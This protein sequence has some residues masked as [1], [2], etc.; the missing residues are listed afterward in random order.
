[1]P[2]SSP[3]SAF[4]QYKVGRLA[5]ATQ[6]AS[7]AG[8]GDVFVAARAAIVVGASIAEIGG[9]SGRSVEWWH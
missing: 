2:S 5:A 4:N 3:V 9:V 7:S 1:M 6:L 8:L